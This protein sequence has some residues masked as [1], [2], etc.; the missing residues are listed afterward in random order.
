MGAV[1]FNTIRSIKE[2][3]AAVREER[4]LAYRLTTIFLVSIQPVPLIRT[5]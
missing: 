4:P 1:V 3:L 5:K 2:V